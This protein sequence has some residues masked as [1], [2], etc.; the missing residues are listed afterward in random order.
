MRLSPVHGPALAHPHQPVVVE[1]ASGGDVA[2]VV[3][4]AVVV[5]GGCVWGGAAV[6]AG[7][8]SVVDSASVTVVVD[9]TV[10]DDWP[11]VGEGF[12]LPGCSEVVDTAGSAPVLSTKPDR[13]MRPPTAATRTS[14]RAKINQPGRP[15]GPAGSGSA[16]SRRSLTSA[17]TGGAMILVGSSGRAAFTSGDGGIGRCSTATARRASSTWWAVRGRSVGSFASSRTISESRAAGIDGSIEDGRGACSLM[18]R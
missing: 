15:V 5:L 7:G 1:D 8:V 11:V 6:V 18:S 16:I 10:V 14:A 9:S 13:K 17:K 4:G 3:G 12:E 2:V